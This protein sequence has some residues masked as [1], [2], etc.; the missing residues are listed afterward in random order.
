MTDR[1][2]ADAQLLEGRIA[3][4]TGASRGIGRAVALDLARCGM[5]VF[6]VARTE[7]DLEALAGECGAIPTVADVTHEGPVRG[8]FERVEAETG[9][10][11][12]LVVNAAGVF[13]IAPIAETRIEDFDRQIEVNLRGAFLVTRAAVRAMTARGT[14]R[15]LNIG[16]IAG[17]TA[18][19]GNGA[20]S[21]SKFGLRGLHEVL[22]EELRGTGIAATLLE[23]G[24]CDTPIWDPLDPDS[25]E[26]LPGRADML[27]P[28]EVAEAVRFVAT[29][30]ERVRIPR[31]PIE[32]G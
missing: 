20:Y 21:A 10:A 6:A 8:V 22:V 12:D 18:F 19:P 9:G 5:T 26:N 29:R 23:P 15:I 24:A 32:P 28:Q 1:S 7:A 17:H 25:S 30:P 13:G 31:L 14:G 16:S 2:P 11:P 27:S 4:V 3:V